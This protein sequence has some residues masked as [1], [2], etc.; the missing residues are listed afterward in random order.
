MAR[1][2]VGVSQLW[3]DGLCQGDPLLLLT[4]SQVPALPQPCPPLTPSIPRS[5][6]AKEPAKWEGDP[7]GVKSEVVLGGEQARECQAVCAH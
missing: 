7:E 1:Q 6:R 4:A 2:V 3:G 5:R